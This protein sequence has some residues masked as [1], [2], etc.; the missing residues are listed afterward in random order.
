MPTI[1]YGYSSEQEFVMRILAATVTIVAV[2]FLMFAVVD[3]KPGGAP[4]SMKQ[5]FE[6]N[7][8]ATPDE[9]YRAEQRIKAHA[10]STGR[11][12]RNTRFL[13]NT[14]DRPKGA[15]AHYR[16][17]W[18]TGRF[19][20]FEDRIENESIGDPTVVVP[21]RD[22]AEVNVL[23]HE[24]HIEYTEEDGDRKR[25]G[26]MLSSDDD[27]QKAEGARDIDRLRDLI[28]ELR[29]EPRDG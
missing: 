22:I 15:L 2:A 4:P 29:N 17:A 10:K 25:I 7:P 26:F 24:L 1:S 11:S 12:G 16:F 3:P 20:V 14:Y 9:I 13:G 27:V 6:Q 19:T 28:E 5:F 18:D 21:I 23:G 8:D